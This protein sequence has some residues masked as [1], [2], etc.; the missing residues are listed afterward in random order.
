[1]TSDPTT[2]GEARRTISSIPVLRRTLLWSAAATIVLGAVAAAIGFWAAGMPGLLS[3]LAGVVLAALFLSMT[4]VTILIANRWYGDPLFVPIFFGGVL[5]G[6]LLKFILFFI[7]LVVLRQQ[8]WVEPLIFFLAVVAG[9]IFTLIIDVVVMLKTR[10][11]Y[12]TD[13]AAALPETDS[14]QDS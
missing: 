2:P 1:M 6:W 12:V 14:E 4:A 8:E 10:M 11:P 7:V 13:T 9:V 3:A 5:G